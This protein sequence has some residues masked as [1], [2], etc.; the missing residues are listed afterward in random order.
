[1]NTELIEQL[2]A[3]FCMHKKR[4]SGDVH[5]D[6]ECGPLDEQATNALMAR[7]VDEIKELEAR[8]NHSGAVKRKINREVLA[9][10]HEMSPTNPNE[11]YIPP[12]TLARR[13]AKA[14]AEIERLRALQFLPSG[15]PLRKALDEIERLRKW[16][17]P[18]DF[19]AV[20]CLCGSTRFMDEFHAAGWRLTLNGCIVLTVGVCKHAQDHGGEALGQDVA[21]RLDELH[22]RKID[23][24]DLV[25]VLNVDGY[26]GDSTRGEIEYALAIGKR[27]QYLEPEAAEAANQRHGGE[28]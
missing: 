12:V 6:R 4:W 16:E 18:K 27:I 10:L 21:D 13:A 24:A 15:E 19:P 20:V 9:E 8:L 3:G 23:L 2:E 1:M 22:K 25:Y 17:R 11:H 14:E 5:G 28:T 26:V 7:A